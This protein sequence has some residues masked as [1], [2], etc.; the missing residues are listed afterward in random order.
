MKIINHINFINCNKE[1]QNILQSKIEELIQ[2]D[3]I[4]PCHSNQLFTE[5]EIFGALD[6]NL[7]CHIKCSCNKVI[8]SFTGNTDMSKITFSNNQA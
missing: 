3:S 4:K 8:T 5:I 1:N 7:K 6:Y 2:M